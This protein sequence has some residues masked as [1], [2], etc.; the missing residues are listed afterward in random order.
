[1]AGCAN[2]QLATPADGRRLVERGIR[3][4]PDFVVNSGGVINIAQELAGYDQQ[5]AYTKVKG[6]FDTTLRVLLVSQE[7][8]V[9]PNEVAEAMAEQRIAG[10]QAVLRPTGVRRFDGTARRRA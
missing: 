3:Y 9:S 10:V 2:N 5:K 4:A 6:I 1:M 7:H 8:G